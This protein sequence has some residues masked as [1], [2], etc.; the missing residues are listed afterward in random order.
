MPVVISDSMISYGMGPKKLC[1]DLNGD[2]FPLELADAKKLYYKYCDTLHV[3]VNFLRNSG[4]LAFEHGYLANING[5]RRYWNKPK[6]EDYPLGYKDEKYQ[7]KK[8]AIEREGGNFLI[9]SVNADITKKA[10]TEIRSYAKKN[11]V[12]TNFINAVYDEIVTRTH[13]DDSPGFHEAKLKI[14]RKVAEEVV[15]SVPMLV[16]G[17]VGPHW[18]K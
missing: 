7:A 8:G 10:M 18:N 2:G 4:K 12:R 16:D 13:K 3:S 9:Q 1:E 17:F 6:P 14:M 15:T 11:K 5:R